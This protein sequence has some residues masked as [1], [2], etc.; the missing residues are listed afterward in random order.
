MRL[1]EIDPVDIM[2]ASLEASQK[3]RIHIPRFDTPQTSIRVYF[4]VHTVDT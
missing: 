1:L 3:A 2:A 4:I